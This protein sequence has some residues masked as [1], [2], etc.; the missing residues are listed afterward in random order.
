[1]FFY[2]A[3]GRPVLGSHVTNHVTL[4]A[5][6]NWPTGPVVTWPAPPRR[7]WPNT[8]TTSTTLLPHPLPPHHLDL[9]PLHR[10]HRAAVPPRRRRHPQRSSMEGAW[11]IFPPT[12]LICRQLISWSSVSCLLRSPPTSTCDPITIKLSNN[13]ELIPPI[14]PPTAT[15][16]IDQRLFII[17]WDSFAFLPFV[18]IFFHLP[19]FAFLFYTFFVLKNNK[20]KYSYYSY[21]WGFFQILWDFRVHNANL[22]FQQFQ[23]TPMHKLTW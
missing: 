15:T 8:A 18:R 17:L 9:R 22:T 5:N 10:E 13:C 11:P 19:G 20:K 2:A 6:H 7:Y 1:M 12:L 4:P 14:P 23:S 21:F 3:N 16:F